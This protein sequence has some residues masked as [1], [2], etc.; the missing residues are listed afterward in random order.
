M[1]QLPWPPS[2]SLCSWLN[3]FNETYHFPNVPCC[4]SD[5]HQILA[6]LLPS[7]QRSGHQCHSIQNSQESLHR[8]YF[9]HLHKFRASVLCYGPEMREKDH[10]SRRAIMK[11]RESLQAGGRDK[12]TSLCI[13][14]FFFLQASKI[15]QVS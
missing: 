14:D 3:L 2:S 9:Q 1:F 15:I 4:H 8:F 7:Q 5:N 12:Y 10:H 6:D 11:Q 13:R